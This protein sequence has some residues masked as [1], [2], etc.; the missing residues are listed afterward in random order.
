MVSKVEPVGRYTA[1]ASVCE[2]GNFIIAIFLADVKEKNVSD[3]CRK[4]T[5]C[6]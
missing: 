1:G 2:Y 5:F 4:T 3:K 6:S